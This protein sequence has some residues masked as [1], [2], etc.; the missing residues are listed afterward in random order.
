MTS[1]DVPNQIMRTS[2]GGQVEFPLRV[3]ST[4]PVDSRENLS[5]Q[6]CDVLAGLTARIFDKR[7]TGDER[8]FLNDVL[9]A[10]LGESLVNGIRF[11]PVFPD[12]IPP[13]PLTGPD[14][15]DRMAGIIFGPHHAHRPHNGD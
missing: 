14:N 7:I 2:S 9:R 15:P 13:R 6:F 8:E 1:A 4:T 5:G 10:R 11:E 3:I 12:Q